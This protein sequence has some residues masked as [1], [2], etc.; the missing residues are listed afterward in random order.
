[1]KKIEN[2]PCPKEVAERRSFLKGAAIT[3][4]TVSSGALAANVLA[5]EPGMEKPI[6]SK[7]G[8]QETAHVKEYYRRARF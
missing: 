2:S 8:Y 6:Q 3:T 4:A 5:D 1:M 7:S